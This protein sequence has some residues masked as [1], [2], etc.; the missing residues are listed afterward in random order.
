M[1]A[2]HVLL[3]LVNLLCLGIASTFDVLCA[4]KKSQ[5]VINCTEKVL[6]GKPQPFLIVFYLSTIA[7]ALAFLT[8]LYFNPTLLE[9]CGFKKAFKKLV[10]KGSFWSY[11]ITL[12][13][14]V[15]DYVFI[16]FNQT[17]KSVN[18]AVI[19]GLII[20]LATK[21]IVA[22]IFNY[23]FPVK[24]PWNERNFVNL[25]IWLVYWATLILFFFATTHFAVAIALD[26]AEKLSPLG[27]VQIGSHNFGKVSR[28][29]LLGIKATFIGRLFIFYWNKIFHGDRDLFST[30]SVLNPIRQQPTARMRLRAHSV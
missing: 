16:V 1:I 11:N 20:F 24:F 10:G 22:Y 26:V 17:V 2:F 21:L 14:F 13:F 18:R 7:N 23:V 28:L 19:V 30:F 27:K 6:V 29:V 8:I 5:S 25:Y 4:V 9:F 12:V 15:S 3:W